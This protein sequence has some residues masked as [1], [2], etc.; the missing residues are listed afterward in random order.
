MLVIYYLDDT[1]TLIHYPDDDASRSMLP[2]RCFPIDASRSML[3]DRCFPID[4][5]Q[6]ML[7]D[8]RR[9]S[10]I[11]TTDDAHLL[12]RR[13]SHGRSSIPTKRRQTRRKHVFSVS[14]FPLF[15]TRASGCRKLLPG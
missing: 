7:P 4:A 15:I 10:T 6:S 1:T 14:F 12:S 11:P 8:R 2:D 13:R 5:S 9:S 3:P